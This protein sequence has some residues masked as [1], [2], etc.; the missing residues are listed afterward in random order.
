MRPFATV[1]A[2][3]RKAD[4]SFRQKE[5]ELQEELAETEQKL[6]ALQQGKSAESATILTSE[7]Q[8]ELARFRDDKVRIRKDLRKVRRQLDADIESLGTRMKLLNIGLV[9]VLLTIGALFMLWWRRR[10]IAK[11]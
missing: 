7:Q 8:A 5:K 6:N 3:K 2:I 1:D 11:A 9:P 4:Q 10:E